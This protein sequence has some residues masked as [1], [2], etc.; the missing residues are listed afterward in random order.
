MVNSFRSTSGGW[1]AN[2]QL[3]S[4]EVLMSVHQG[5]CGFNSLLYAVWKG[6]IGDDGLW[7]SSA[8]AGGPRAAAGS[9]L[10]STYL[11]VPASWTRVPHIYYVAV[12][13]NVH[14]LAWPGTN[15]IHR[16]VPHDAGGPPVA[17]GSALTSATCFGGNPLVYYVAGDN[18]V[19][20]LAWTGSNWTHRAVSRDAGGPPAAS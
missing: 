12:D 11:V 3:A 7:F 20:E 19:H 2:G 1:I 9:Q 16:A 15:W 10:T 8:D 6:V 18:G 4:L 13:K 14:E 5:L 17:A